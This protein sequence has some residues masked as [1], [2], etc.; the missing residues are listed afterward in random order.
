MLRELV[1]FFGLLD[2]FTLTDEDTAGSVKYYGYTREGGAYRIMKYDSTAGTYTFNMGKNMTN[3]ATRWAAR[4][5]ATAY[6][7][8][9][10]LPRNI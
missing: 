2:G 9:G 8:A 10:T 1:G 7:Q 3:Y 4:A 6:V 5:S